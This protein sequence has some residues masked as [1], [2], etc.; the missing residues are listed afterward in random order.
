MQ[1][2]DAQRFFI[3]LINGVEYLHNRGKHYLTILDLSL[4]FIIWMFI[5]ISFSGIAHR[6]LKPENLLL[7]DHGKSETDYF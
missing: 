4:L 6:D 7:D 3:Q 5:M 1:E 2:T